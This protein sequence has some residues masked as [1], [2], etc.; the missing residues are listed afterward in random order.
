MNAPTSSNTYGVKA[1]CWMI[2]SEGL[3][4]KAARLV[5][6]LRQIPTVQ[7]SRVSIAG[8]HPAPSSI[9]A[10]RSLGNRSKTPSMSIIDIK[11][12]IA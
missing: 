4:L 7:S 2:C 10:P 9:A 1:I 8:T 6:V 3:R 5:S 12:S 11:V